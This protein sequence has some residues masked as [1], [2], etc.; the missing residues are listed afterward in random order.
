MSD[1]NENIIITVEDIERY[2]RFLNFWGSNA[3]YIKILMYITYPA[4]CNSE[5]M[6]EC[7]YHI[8]INYLLY[9]N[10]VRNLQYLLALLHNVH[11]HLFLQTR[12]RCVTGLRKSLSHSLGRRFCVFMGD[13]QISLKISYLRHWVIVIWQC[14][15]VLKCLCH[16]E[17]WVGRMEWMLSN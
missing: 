15:C 3:T 17:G 10:I 5:T 7:R 2:V 8:I 12:Q 16:H 9:T 13:W 11:L 1:S 14:Q 6:F 4:V